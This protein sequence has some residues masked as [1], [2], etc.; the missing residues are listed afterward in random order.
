MCSTFHTRSTPQTS[1]SAA[2]IRVYLC[3]WTKRYIILI[4]KAKLNGLFTYIDADSP[5]HYCSPGAAVAWVVMWSILTNH[6]WGCTVTIIIIIS[7]RFNSGCFVVHLN[8]AVLLIVNSNYCTIS[9]HVNRVFWPAFW[10]IQCLALSRER[11]TR[12]RRTRAFSYLS[13]F[14]AALTAACC[15]TALLGTGNRSYELR[16]HTGSVNVSSLWWTH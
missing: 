10:Y 3:S 8:C 4:L 1:C 7:K 14:C 15:W 2:H 11:N 9:L 16:A 12:P 6:C 13:L 5:Q